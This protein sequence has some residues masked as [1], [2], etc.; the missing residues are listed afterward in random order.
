MK[1]YICA[2]VKIGHQTLLE[3]LTAP[4]HNPLK[5]KQKSNLLLFYSFG[6]YSWVQLHF[7]SWLFEE[8]TS[9][10]LKDEKIIHS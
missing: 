10:V 3:R 9:M 8:E 1:L 5:V 2:Q 7:V 4:S 6:G